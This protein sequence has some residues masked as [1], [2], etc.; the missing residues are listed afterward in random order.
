MAV[1]ITK[2]EL[3]EIQRLNRNARAKLRR[4]EKRYGIREEIAV[5]APKTFTS[6]KEEGSVIQRSGFF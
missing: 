2:K 5:K 6:R 3:A 4:I 1:R